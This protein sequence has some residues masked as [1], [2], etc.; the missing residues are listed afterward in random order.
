MKYL[1]IVLNTRVVLMF[2]ALCW[3]VSLQGC[4]QYYKVK[5]VSNV[6]VQDMEKFIAQKKFIIVHQ[7]SEFRHLSNARMT[8]GVLAG[9]LVALTEN[10]LKFKSTKPTGA[11]RYKNNS[12]HREKYVTNEVHLYLQKSVIQDFGSAKQVMIPLSDI[13]YTDVYLIAEGRS[14]ISWVAPLVIGAGTA[15]IGSLIIVVSTLGNQWH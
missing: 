2:F 8:E 9:E 15:F 14:T 7:D 6:T 5:K 13:A 12:K 4:M 10:Q 11:T 1:K 3:L